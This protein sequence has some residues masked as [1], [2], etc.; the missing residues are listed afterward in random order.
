MRDQLMRY[1][2]ARRSAGDDRLPS[3]RTL[4]DSLRT[5]RITLREALARLEAEGI[6]YRETRRGWFI[7]PQ[8]I[9]YNPLSRGYFNKMALGQGRAPR[10]ELIESG[11]Q[12]PPPFVASIL[13]LED[14][15]R[16]LILIRRVRYLEDRP[17]LYVEHYLDPD[18]FPGILD[19]DLTTS[20]TE[21]YISK[22]QIKLGDSQ[23]YISSNS[24]NGD[25]AGLLHASQGS[26][27]LHIARVNY[28]L[29]GRAIDCDLEFWR[30][31]ALLVHI[32]PLSTPTD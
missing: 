27:A 14:D 15:A 32:R 5:T 6:I 24:L 7:S 10:T 30:H 17:V 26:P 9:V 16:D 23:S 2:D 3:E 4:A 31:D 18:V 8:R 25:M 11:F 28:D 12:S 13:G 29:A 22:Y 20:L 19:E 1:I 21:I